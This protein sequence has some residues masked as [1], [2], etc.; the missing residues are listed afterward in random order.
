M[1][2]YIKST[3]T[4]SYIDELE[5]KIEIIKRRLND[6]EEPEDE[7]VDDYEE[8]QYLEDELR[9]AWAEDEAEWDYVRNAQE[10][11]PDGSL[12]LYGATDVKADEELV[13]VLVKTQDGNWNL[14]FSQIPESQADAIW[15]A[16]FATG[17]NRISIETERGKQIRRSNYKSLGYSDGEIDNM[18][19]SFFRKGR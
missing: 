19:N 8:L 10:F 13:D 11:N 2:R 15:R 1:K 18:M 5:T 17:E 4:R 3:D 16:G 14:L 6:P 12:K 9:H 7:R